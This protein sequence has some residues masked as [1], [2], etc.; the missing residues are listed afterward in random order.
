MLQ[1]T[2][3]LQTPS[4]NS[5]PECVPEGGCSQSHGRTL[6]R[7][8]HVP[9][10][11]LHPHLISAEP[12]RVS[13]WEP[14][15]PGPEE[16]DWGLVTA[17]G[18]DPFGV[19]VLT[20]AGANMREVQEANSG[21]CPPPHTWGSTSAMGLLFQHLSG[22]PATRSRRHTAEQSHPTRLRAL[23]GFGNGLLLTLSRQSQYC[24]F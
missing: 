11:A 21:T 14:C 4:G 10:L 16:G 24:W 23:G 6:P 12:A 13:S 1:A 18:A 5:K 7:Y 15:K 2:L 22:S 19:T 8:L 3:W 9:P 20:A 17:V